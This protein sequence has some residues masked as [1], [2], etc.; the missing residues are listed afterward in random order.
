MTESYLSAAQR[1]FDDAEL[2]HRKNRLDN[3]SHHYGVAGECA[4]KAVCVEEAGTRP[5]KHFDDLPLKDLRVS[6]VA[7]LAGRKGQRMRVVLPSLFAG[8]SIN[9]RYAATGH[10]SAAQIEQWRA[11]AKRALTL[12]QGL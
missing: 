4:V 11:D 5:H 3:A 1:H 10:T 7:N 6:A 9:N 8:W 2:L 12:M